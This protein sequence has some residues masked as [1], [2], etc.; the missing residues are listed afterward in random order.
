MR[1]RCHYNIKS[2]LVQLSIRFYVIYTDFNNDYQ[3][4]GHFVKTVHRL[5]A[6][7]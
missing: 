4:I 5:D 6:T 2:E 1:S 7:P 3:T